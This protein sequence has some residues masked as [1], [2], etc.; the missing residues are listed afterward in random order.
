MLFPVT[1]Y[2][3]SGKVKEVISKE[4]LHRRHWKNFHNNEGSYTGAGRQTISK[5]LKRKLDAQFPEALMNSR[6]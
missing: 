2:N 6:N 1:I 3:A 4:R 5:E